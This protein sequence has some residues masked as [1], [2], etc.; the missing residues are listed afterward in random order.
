LNY[1]PCDRSLL[2]GVQSLPPACHAQFDLASGFASRAT[3]NLAAKFRDKRSFASQNEC[4]RRAGG[5]DRR[6][7]CAS[8][9]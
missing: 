2:R 3:G 5:A 6:C 4:R 7:R 9:W 8:V 1:V